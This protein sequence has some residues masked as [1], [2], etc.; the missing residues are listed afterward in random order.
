LHQHKK[1][2]GRLASQL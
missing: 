1:I 2:W